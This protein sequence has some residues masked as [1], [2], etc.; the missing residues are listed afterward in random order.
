MS[1]SAIPALE[2]SGGCSSNPLGTS[3]QAPTGLC[4]SAPCW[5]LGASPEV[6]SL[7]SSLFSG[8]C[9][10]DPSCLCFPGLAAWSLQLL[11][12]LGSTWYPL[13]GPWPE[14][15]LKAVSGAVIGLTSYV[16]LLGDHLLLEVQCLVCVPYCCCCLRFLL[17][18]VPVTLSWLESEVPANVYRGMLCVRHCSRCWGPISE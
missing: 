15:S 13:S 14:N 6:L 7:G 18:L 16:S 10:L 5:I 2:S 17:H 12:L 1:L 3:V 11:S 9:P 8:L 4:E